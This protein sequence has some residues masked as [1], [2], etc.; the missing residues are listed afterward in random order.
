MDL[1]D[2]PDELRG[3]TRRGGMSVSNS[4]LIRPDRGPEDGYSIRQH[5]GF[6][7]CLCVTMTTGR[8]RGPRDYAIPAR[9]EPRLRRVSGRQQ[10]PVP[11]EVSSVHKQT[12]RVR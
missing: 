7:R 12:H 5:N 1:V 8:D 4:A 3:V 9:D 10:H 2:V 11:E 6:P